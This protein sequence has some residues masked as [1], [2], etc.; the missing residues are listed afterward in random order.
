ME[1]SDLQEVERRRADFK[2]HAGKAAKALF[3]EAMERAAVAKAEHDGYLKR[4]ATK[5]R[6]GCDGA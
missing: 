3:A 5:R 2:E 1:A 4:M 6:K